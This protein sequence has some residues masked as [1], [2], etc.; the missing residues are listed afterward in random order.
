M[1]PK[2]CVVVMS[3]LAA[4]VPVL[5]AEPEK[6][7]RA[8]SVAGTAV[9]RTV[10]DI[11]VWHVTT[12][13]YDKDLLR[14]KES[15][16]KKLKAVLALK[17]ELAV[18]PED[19]QTGHLSIRREY[20]RDAHGHRTEFKHFAV[21]RNVTLKQRDLKRFDEFLTKLVSAAEMEVRFNFES[22]R[23]H[24]LRADTRL[25]ALRVARDKAEAMT[26]ELGTKLGKVLTIDELRPSD[27]SREWAGS[28]IAFTAAGDRPAVDVASGT[29][30]PGAIEVQITVY[31]AFEIE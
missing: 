21:T 7:T 4:A 10:P 31:A 18:K 17:D 19:L 24:E 8:V 25:K 12:S 5:A 23:I 3:M 14:A 9:T 13:D 1:Y 22:S 26:R 11:I 27:R 28:N 29:F 6:P 2:L 15:S 16:D 20:H 30:A